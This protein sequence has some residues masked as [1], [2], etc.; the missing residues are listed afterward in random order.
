MRKKNRVYFGGHVM[1][2]RPRRTPHHHHSWV[3]QLCLY[4]GVVGAF[5]ASLLYRPG[6]GAR[7]V[8]GGPEDVHAQ[9]P[10]QGRGELGALRSPS[11]T[12]LPPTL[13]ASLLLLEAGA[14]V[15]ILRPQMRCCES[16]PRKWQ[17][18]DCVLLKIS[19]SLL[20][21]PGGDAFQEKDAVT[22]L[23]CF[24]LPVHQVSL[25]VNVRYG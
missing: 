24:I 5:D 3:S 8:A 4:S 20:V 9:C 7:A 16:R 10:G 18:Y 13:Q 14:S 23:M 22:D 12:E 11:R 2:P 15:G 17:G 1:P 6:G 19:F 21:P 25:Q